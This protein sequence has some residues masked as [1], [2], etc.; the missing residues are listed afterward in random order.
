[1]L[2]HAANS[3]IFFG[4]CLFFNPLSA[5]IK[6]IQ[7]L[8]ELEGTIE[9]LKSSDWMLFDI[10][11]TVT[12]PSHPALQMNYLKQNKQRFRDELA[13]FT[14]EQKELIPALISQVPSQL[15]DPTILDIIQKLHDR[16]I[17]TI[18]FT[19][20]DTSVIPKIGYLPT[21]R[22]NELQ[23]LG[24][25]FHSTSSVF[26]QE[27]I[28]FSEF[29]E[30]RGTFPLYQ[31]GILY[32]N[33]TPPKGE[34]LVAFIN[35]VT[36]K[37]AR[38]VFVDD[39][40]DNLQSVDEELKKLGIPFL[41]LHYKPKI[42]DNDLSK[43]SESDW[44]SLWSKIRESIK[45]INYLDGILKTS[46]VNAIQW[47]SQQ[48]PQDALIIFDIGNVILVHKDTI[49]KGEHR[50]WMKEWF[51]REAPQIG[52]NERRLLAGIVDR[53]ATL[54][55]VNESLPTI[56]NTAKGRMKVVALSK[57][58]CGSTGENVTFEEQR[59]ASLKNVG[60][61]FD[62]PFPNACGWI[63]KGL[64]ASY[65]SGLIQTE[66]PLKGPVLRAFLQHVNWKP[67]AILFVD[68]LKDQCDS[69]WLTAKDLAI[70]TLCIH[71]TEGTDRKHSL[72][73]KIADLQLRTLVNEKRWISDE[74]ARQQIKQ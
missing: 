24:I 59:L 26:P 40:L 49:L 42:N 28:E 10:D 15:I 50:T 67:S 54:S 70:P 21:W 3:L 27:S 65:A 18:G 51:D 4:L 53:E 35:R 63:D 1:M 74:T 69:I 55:L 17:P 60:I 13:K 68:D 62:E 8:S 61:S 39:T 44:Q 38:I 46:H 14:D 32:S 66:A 56:I 30:F 72:D 7:N 19:A 37:P 41:G 52:A 11:Y 71:Y 47:A 31:D 64:A 20:L 58:L 23:R 33:V 2:R 73:P 57:F 29:P 22:F 12:E 25:N 48:M 43:V 16:K 5:E 45:D 34:V 9:S 36:N 6:E